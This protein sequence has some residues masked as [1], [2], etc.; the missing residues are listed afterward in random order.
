MA[1]SDDDTYD[2]IHDEEPLTIGDTLRR[3]RYTLT[4]EQYT[5][6]S[7]DVTDLLW[8]QVLEQRAIRGW[9]VVLCAL[10]AVVAAALVLPIVL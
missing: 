7:S 2:E 9:L 8:Q 5:D 4:P 1:T 3:W 6:E 10:V